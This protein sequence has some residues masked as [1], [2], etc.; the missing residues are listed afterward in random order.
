MP[1]FD[2]ELTDAQIAAVTNYVTKQFGNPRST[3]SAEEVGKLR[4]VP[5]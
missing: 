2:R 1:A 3:S 5:Q 4:A